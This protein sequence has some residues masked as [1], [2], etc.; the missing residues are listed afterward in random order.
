MQ[1][2]WNWRQR[3]TRRATRRLAGVDGAGACV[4]FALS[5]SLATGTSPLVLKAF[6]SLSTHTQKS[7][8]AGEEA[9]SANSEGR[10]PKPNLRGI[11][12]FGNMAGK[13]LIIATSY[14]GQLGDAPTGTW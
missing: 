4:T 2:R 10:R 7:D 9:E 6:I 8:M 12:K 5:E 3:G 1:H 14:N 13:I 11:P